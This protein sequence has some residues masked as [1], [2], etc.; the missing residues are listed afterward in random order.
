MPTVSDSTDFAMP[1]QAAMA[2]A[3]GPYL[4]ECGSGVSLD[5]NRVSFKGGVTLSSLA[6][7]CSLSTLAPE[8]LMDGLPQSVVRSWPTGK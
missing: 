1:G 3:L 6:S 2:C 5:D 7:M 8:L 4:A